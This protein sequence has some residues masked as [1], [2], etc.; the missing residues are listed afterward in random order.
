MHVE[1]SVAFNFVISYLY[2]KLPRRRVD[3]FG[4][5]LKTG[6]QKKFEGHWYPDKPFKG[7]AFRCIRVNG[8]KMDPVIITAAFNAGLDIEEVKGYLPAELTLWID[9]SEVSYRIG[10]KGPIRILYS[11]RKEEDPETTADREVQAVSR[12]FNPEAQCFQPID[13]LSS[14]MNNLSLS[15]SSSNSSGAWSTSTSPST[16]LFTSAAASPAPAIF[17]NK[18]QE[19]PKFTAAT[20]AQTKFGS[21]KLK[22]QVKRPTRLSPTEFGNFF[23]QRST[24][25]AAAM[26]NAFAGVPSPPQRP[27]SLSPRDQRIEFMVDQQ[28][29]LLIQAQQSQHNPF[30]QQQTAAAAAAAYMGDL[31]RH[32]SPSHLSPGSF[33]PGFNDP[34]STSSPVNSLSPDGHKSFMDGLNINPVSYPGQLHHLLVAN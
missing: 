13:S 23:R 15:P 4:Q 33:N 24:A 17:Q 20:F 10:E 25:A 3:M 32:T 8:E 7:S 1:V 19:M 18:E 28:Q 14:S 34:F 26:Q 6:L 30:Q 29:R 5:E 21:T 12:G 11:D 31:Y 9:P 16:A 27:Q 2:N 22:T